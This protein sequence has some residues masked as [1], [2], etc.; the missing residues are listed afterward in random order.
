MNEEDAFAQ[1]MAE[2]RRLAEERGVAWLFRGD[3]TAQRSAF[4]SGVSPSD[5]LES[6]DAMCEWRGCG[7]GGGGG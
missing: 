4:E 6:Y 7:C 1:W 2:L 5:E 3:G